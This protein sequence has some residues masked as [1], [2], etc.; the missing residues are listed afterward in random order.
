[1]KVKVIEMSVRIGSASIDERGKISGGAAGDQT[2]REVYIR[3]YYLHKKGWVCLRAKDSNIAE[4]IAKCM[5]DA[6]ANPCIGYD[7]GQRDT[8][9]NTV[10]ESGFRCDTDSL[11]INVE[12]DCSSLIRV[13]LGYA[14]IDVNNFNTASEKTLIM[15]TG[16]F[17]EVA[18]S[19]NGSNL[20]RGDILVT[21][22][23]GHTVVVVSGDDYVEAEKLNVDG[24]WGIKTTTRLQE[25]FGTTVDGE[26]SNQWACYKEK[27]PGLDSGWK[28]V[29]RPNG[30]GSQLIKAMQRFS[31]MPSKE[32]DGEIGSK[33]IKAFQ[34]KFG[35][36]IVDGYVSAPSNLVKAI[37]QWAN[38]QK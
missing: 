34:R 17:T 15:K 23:K 13:C 25:I 2:G 38:N 27:N 19:D 18:V 9:F 26:V 29:S 10:W 11:K 28:W 35:C 33:T 37:Q 36:S 6:C 5:E 4:R 7:Q 3:D 1:M 24:Y 30:R 21:K 8:L 14:G 32:V 12:C 20:K 16:M 22:S 31:G